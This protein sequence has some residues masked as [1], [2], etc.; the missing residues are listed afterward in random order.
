MRLP[1][2]LGGKN[3]ADVYEF[4]ASNDYTVRLLSQTKAFLNIFCFYK[5]V[6]M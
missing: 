2:N 6:C 4:E 1:E 5:M 3:V